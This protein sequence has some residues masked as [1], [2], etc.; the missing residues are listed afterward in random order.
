MPVLSSNQDPAVVNVVNP[1]IDIDVTVSTNGACPGQDSI[2]VPAGTSVTNCYVVSNLGDD[3]LNNVVV[4]DGANHILATIAVL[5]TGSSSSF[6][7]PSAPARMSGIELEI[8]LGNS[9][10][11]R[12][13]SPIFLRGS[14]VDTQRE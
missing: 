5:P 3:T 6:S 9:R 13:S 8:S 12:R 2:T 1:S 4:K 7:Q 14:S 10:Q 11:A